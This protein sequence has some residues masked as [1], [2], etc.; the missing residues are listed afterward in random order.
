[1]TGVDMDGEGPCE[2]AN[3]I[4]LP[5]RDLP[6][7]LNRAER[8]VDAGLEKEKIFGG[9]GRGVGGFVRKKR[10]ACVA[11]TLPGCSIMPP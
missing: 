7:L 1:M 8:T 9:E 11:Y 5:I 4:T 6:F 3:S 2:S 10:H